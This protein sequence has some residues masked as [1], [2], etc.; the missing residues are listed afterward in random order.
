M[1]TTS[2]P[3]Y[4]VGK[5]AMNKIYDKFKNKKIKSKMILQIHDELVFEMPKAER[6]IATSIVIS[7]LEII[8]KRCIS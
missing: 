7:N 3:A 5:I 6:E 2:C 8:K 4:Q 1:L